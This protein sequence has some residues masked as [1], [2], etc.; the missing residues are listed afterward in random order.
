MYKYI[1]KIEFIFKGLTIQVQVL[2]P[3]VSR[4]QRARPIG[5]VPSV[6]VFLKDPSPYL[7]E[8]R[9]KTPH[10]SHNFCLLNI[11]DKKSEIRKKVNF[12]FPYQGISYKYY[13]IVPSK[14]FRRHIILFIRN[15]IIQ[16]KCNKH[17]HNKNTTN[18][19][20]RICTFNLIVAYFYIGTLS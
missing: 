14:F 18:N 11:Y 20:K 7:R 4:D 2:R 19:K 15:K 12:F 5:G 6:G 13:E 16:E 1:F 10:Y 17:K 9:R 8:F 3:I